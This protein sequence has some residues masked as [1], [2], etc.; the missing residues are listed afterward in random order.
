MSTPMG[1]RRPPVL[2]VLVLSAC[3]GAATSSPTTLDYYFGSDPRSLDPALSTDVPTGEV[4]SLLFDNL[5]R[6]DVDGTLVP[7]LA[8]SWTV[9]RSGTT[10]TFHLRS[11][12]AFH[13]GRPILAKDVGAS[14]RRALAPGPGGGRGW[15]L[16]PIRGARAFASG[17]GDSLPGLV[18]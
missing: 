6:F 13:D 15:P 7:G 4:A 9:D 1:P 5:T 16:F 12:A 11:G 14:F 2:L 18:V 3:G 8:R 17:Q 10:Y